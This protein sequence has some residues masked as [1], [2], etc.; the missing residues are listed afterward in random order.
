MG[1]LTGPW[2]TSATYKPDGSV[3]TQ[4]LPAAGSLPAETLTYGYDNVGLPLT[5]TSGLD[6][7]ISATAYHNWGDQFQTTLGTGT[8]RVQLQATVDEATRRLTENRVST[9][10][11]TTPNT[12]VAQ[13]IE[14]Y[15]YD[16]AGNVKNIKEVTAAGS[17][18][19][20][21]CFIYDPL[22]R[23]TE[24]W[25]T[26]AATC[27]TTP[28]QAIVGGPDPYW[29]SY[30]YNSIGNRTTDTVHTPGGNTV[31]TYTYPTS[32]ATSVRPHAASSVAI[33]GLNPGSDSYGYD[34]AGNTTTRSIATKP[35]QTLTWDPEGRLASVTDSGGTT[36]YIY[37][38]DGQRLLAYEPGSVTTLYLGNYELRRTTT[39]IT[40]TRHYGIA[41]RT[42]SG[43]LTWIHAD[44]HGTGEVAINPT[45]LAV[46]RRKTDP[47]GN[48][49]GPAAAWPT[50]RG[51]V[52][53]IQDPTGMT[54]LGAREYEPQAG[55]FISVDPMMNLADPT[56]W[57]GY[58]YANNNPTTSSDPD[59]LCTR[60]DDRSGPCANS[61]KAATYV[62]DH[63]PINSDLS[64]PKPCPIPGACNKPPPPAAKTPGQD[65]TRGSTE[66]Q[67][68]QVGGY[69]YFG[70]PDPAQLAAA[71]DKHYAK[72]SAIESDPYMATLLALEA[73]C[74]QADVKCPRAMID[75]LHATYLLLD[76]A[77]NPNCNARCRQL[78][79]DL[80]EYG[81]VVSDFGASVAVAR[82]GG[83][84][85]RAMACGQSFD[86]DTPVLMA[87][88]TTKP[89]KD[90]KVGDYILATDPLTGE[91]APRRVSDLHN[92]LDHDLAD[93]TVNEDGVT[94][95]VHTT[96][97]HPVW[98]ITRSGWVAA[99]DLQPGERLHTATGQTATVAAVHRFVGV[100][101][102]RD[103]TIDRD[104]TYYVEA[105]STQLLVHNCTGPVR[106]SEN[107][108]DTHVLPL[109][110]PGSPGDGSKFN[111]SI[112]PDDYEDLANEV[113]RGAPIP[114]ATDPV[115]GN[116]AHDYD[117]GPGR[118]VGENGETR[119]RV[120]VDPNGNVTSMYPT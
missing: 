79:L 98:S 48:T 64:R 49:R 76:A 37:T 75:D 89:I 41:S 21:Q 73:A 94:Y 107:R 40:C 100:R 28:S 62:G 120:W 34:Q 68:N 38:A 53:G 67:A 4:T 115:T 15:G 31:R 35:T 14:Q 43:G 46:T 96:Q 50:T 97:D 113:V 47:F 51:F 27:Q 45:T 114:A 36:N 88:G 58:T 32:G 118:V 2:T 54:H 78:A 99:G 19:S 81:D 93:I 8:K 71:A 109:H 117:F 106:L 7:Y 10:N 3:A 74:D 70:G 105:G 30:T 12:W 65:W 108:R 92:N 101:V 82:A 119:V 69:Y 110:G 29:T 26:T 42:T 86:P 57:N 66:K 13:L 44:H 16:N 103:L 59:G 84:A 90:V 63:G 104:H 6:S 20:N 24:A 61:P 25:T 52:N 91:T 56:Q 102:M 80:Y 83:K 116:H 1:T 112:D 87:D 60:L 18:V 77:R 95:K 9:E 111:D 72:Y 23:L 17:T 11:Q 85:L 55:R 22:R 39:G 5:M 33:T